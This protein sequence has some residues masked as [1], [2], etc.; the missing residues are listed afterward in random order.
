MDEC[1]RFSDILS[2]PFSAQLCAQLTALERVARCF[3]FPFPMFSSLP[4]LFTIPFRFLHGSSFLLEKRDDSTTEGERSGDKSTSDERGS[5][6]SLDRLLFQRKGWKGIVER[7]REKQEV[8]ED[9]E[10]HGQV[11]PKG[12]IRAKRGGKSRGEFGCAYDVK[13]GPVIWRKFKAL[14]QGNC[15]GVSVPPYAPFP[16]FPLLYLFFFFLSFF[17]SGVCFSSRGERTER[18]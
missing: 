18:V 13:H 2:H 11:E 8:G 16:F 6:R 1:A 15:I 17:F 10:K 3:D 12:K 4:S 7:G 5:A 9:I 14:C